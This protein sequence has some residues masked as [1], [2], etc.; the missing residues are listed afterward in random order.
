MAGRLAASTCWPPLSLPNREGRGDQ[1]CAAFVTGDE[2]AQV[3]Q[4]RPVRLP[5]LAVPGLPDPAVDRPSCCVQAARLAGRWFRLS[6]TTRSWSWP[7]V[8]CAD[9]GG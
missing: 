7:S 3:T 5:G 6:A 9:C 2:I 8:R 4:P 1:S